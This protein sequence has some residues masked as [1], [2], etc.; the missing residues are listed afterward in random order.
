MEWKPNIYEFFGKILLVLIVEVEEE[1][2]TRCG[3]SETQNQETL[4]QN[5]SGMG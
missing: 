1:S 2:L 3:K 4:G 5:L